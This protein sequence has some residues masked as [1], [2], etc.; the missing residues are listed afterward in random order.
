MFILSKVFRWLRFG[1]A[2][3]LIG[4]WSAE[5]KMGQVQ[6]ITYATFMYGGNKKVYMLYTI[7]EEA[8]FKKAVFLF[9]HGFQVQNGYIYYLNFSSELILNE[10]AFDYKPGNLTIYEFLRIS[11]KNSL[12]SIAQLSN[13]QI[14]LMGDNKPRCEIKLTKMSDDFDTDNIRNYIQDNRPNYL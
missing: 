9:K 14:V 4:T 8:T 12:F 7:E 1:S 5:I 2:Y 10:T 3:N 11:Y 13:D 6:A